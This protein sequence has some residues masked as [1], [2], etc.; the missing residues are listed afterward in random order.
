K[1]S[2]MRP[3]SDGEFELPPDLDQNLQLL[4][5]TQV[6]TYCIVSYD[7]E[8][9]DWQGWTQVDRTAQPDTFT[10]VDDFDGLGGGSW[11]GLVPL[12]GT[13]SM[14]CGTRPDTNDPYLCSWID[15]PGYGNNWDQ[16]LVTDPIYFTGILTWSYK[17][18]FDS[19]PDWDQ[20]FIEYDAGGFDWR[21][22]ATYEGEMDTTAVHELHL[23]HVSTKLRFHFVSDGSWSDQDGLWDTDGAFIVDSITIADEQGFIDYEDFEAASVGDKDV[24]IWHAST[25]TAYGIYSKLW[26]NLWETD[27]CGNNFGT[28]IAFFYVPFYPDD[29]PHTPFCAGGGGIEEP[30]QNEYVLSPVIDMTRYSTNCDEHQDADIPPGELS[31]LGGSLLKFTVYRDLPVLNCVYYNWMVRSIDENGCPGHWQDRGFGYYGPDKAYIYS[32]FEIGDLVLTDRIQVSLHCMDMCAFWYEV[33]CTCEDHTSSPWFDNVRILQYKTAGPQWS[34]RDLDLFQD[35]F[36]EE[37]F[38]IES[39][40]RADAANDILPNDDPVIDPGD[41]IVVR[42]TSPLG[43]SIRENAGGPE[44]YL[45]VKAEYLGPMTPP[46]G[47]KPQYLYGPTLEG[48]YGHYVSDDGAMWTVIQA[49]TARTWGGHP[50]YDMYTLDLNDSLLTRGYM[51]SYYFSAWDNAGIRSTLPKYAETK[52]GLCFPNCNWPYKA[53]SYIFEFTCLPTGSSDILYV[54]DFHGRGTFW[55]MA[56]QY[57][58]PTFLAG[59]PGTN[60]PDRYDVNSP[61]SNVSNGPGS[62]AKHY[63]LTTAYNTIIWDSGNLDD[64]TISEGTVYSDKSNDCQML[65]DWMNLSEHE[66]GLWVC[67]DDIAKDLDGAY[68]PQALELLT[69]WCGVTLVDN[70]YFELTGGVQNLGDPL[71]LI[72]AAPAP[73][74][75]SIPPP[76]TLVADGGCEDVNGFDVLEKA[77]NGNYA[78]QYPDFQGNPYYAA[79]QNVDINSN[80]YEVRTMW[81]GFSFMY[82]RDHI[83]QV[84][85][86][87]NRIM[88]RVLDWMWHVWNPD[89]TETDPVP[90][91]NRLAQNYPNPFNPVTTIRFSI[92]E[93]GHV[94]VRIYNVAGQLVRTLVDEVLEAGPHAIMWNGKNNLGTDAASGV[95]FYEMKTSSFR[96]TRK[97]VLLR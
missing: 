3:W 61:S 81:F 54:D 5:A 92:R 66:C 89:I 76:E 59:I 82:I 33:F 93:K 44:V 45:H 4:T 84:P 74:I 7:F 75:F 72:T 14:W 53:V 71:P 91:V 47:P 94:T 70:S 96:Q 56:E 88:Q 80:G 21:E 79:I 58:N 17:G 30:C 65:I 78:L 23:P 10:H 86:V 26:S 13:K 60:L 11:G 25:K 43:G 69:A 27:P 1:K 28:Q 41:S 31:Q 48:G 73:S 18:H 83:L 22:I 40:C 87:R 12:E 97:M 64:C 67:G 90:S 68:S 2:V 57:Y 19:E 50:I 52:A 20:T 49:E 8:Q 35:T 39:Y 34:Y 95:Y 42:C 16:M 55:G 46:W 9:M 36:P 62:R 85:I 6:D 24:G 37:E 38:D 29:L 63:H 77:G 15:A 51:I 32:T